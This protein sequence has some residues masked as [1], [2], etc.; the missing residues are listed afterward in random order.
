MKQQQEALVSVAAGSGAAFQPQTYEGDNNE[1]LE[2][3]ARAL[4]ADQSNHYDPSISNQLAT[5]FCYSCFASM[6]FLREYYQ[7]TLPKMLTEEQRAATLT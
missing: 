4:C 1:V 7:V 2:I 3:V 6:Q 5:V